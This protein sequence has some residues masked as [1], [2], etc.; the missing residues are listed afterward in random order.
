MKRSCVLSCALVVLVACLSLIGGCAGFSALVGGGSYNI[1]GRV[2]ELPAVCGLP[3]CCGAL[4]V[5][6]LPAG[7]AVVSVVSKKTKKTAPTPAPAPTP[8]PDPAA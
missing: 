5:W 3:A 2:H 8:T 7:L 4:A 1:G 6:L